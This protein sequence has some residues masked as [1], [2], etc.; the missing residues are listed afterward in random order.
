MRFIACLFISVAIWG[1]SKSTP[2]STA[3]PIPEA[4]WTKHEVKDAGLVFGL[5]AGWQVA[6]E[7]NGKVQVQQ[8]QEALAQAKAQFDDIRM[9]VSASEPPAPSKRLLTTYTILSLKPKTLPKSADDLL[10]S[11]LA[12]LVADYPNGDPQGAVFQLA[13]GPAV[14]TSYTDTATRGQSKGGTPDVVDVISIQFRILRAKEILLLNVTGEKS[15]AD[16]IRKTAE[17]LLHHL[18]V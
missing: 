2:H 5:P 12:D 15:R 1:C 9:V 13:S 17:A 16:E 14:L 10:R 11:S 7:V 4:G 18:S 8:D 3:A 6:N